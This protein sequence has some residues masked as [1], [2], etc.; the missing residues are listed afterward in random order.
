MVLY[1]QLAMVLQR[2]TEAEYN[3]VRIWVLLCAVRDL[4]LCLNFLTFTIGIA[5]VPNILPL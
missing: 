1:I 3:Q 4:E 5:T 2:S